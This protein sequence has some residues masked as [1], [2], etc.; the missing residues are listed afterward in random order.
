M[1][2][3]LLLICFILIG[4]SIKTEFFIY[5]VS[6]DFVTV[7]YEFHKESEYGGFVSIPEIMEINWLSKLEKINS[8]ALHVDLYRKKV[9]CH[10]KEGQAIKLGWIANYNSNSKFKREAFSEN[11]KVLKI[12]RKNKGTQIFTGRDSVV[13]LFKRVSSQRYEIKLNE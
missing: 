6:N 3:S 13:D 12:I 2:K 7:S 4:C 9:V 8:S 11:L 10:I 1:K 5:N